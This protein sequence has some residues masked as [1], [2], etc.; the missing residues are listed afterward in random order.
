MIPFHHQRIPKD[1]AYGYYWTITFTQDTRP[2]PMP[3][4]ALAL[5]GAAGLPVLI[6]GD[7]SPEPKPE[8][9]LSLN[10]TIEQFVLPSTYRPILRY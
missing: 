1:A 4:Q 8:A 2:V 6:E 10:S 3:S 7:I 9:Q 5:T